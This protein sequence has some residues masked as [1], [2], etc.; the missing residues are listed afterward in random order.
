MQNVTQNNA[1]KLLYKKESYEIRGICFNLYKKFRNAYKEIIYHN[2][3]VHELGQKDFSIEKNKQIPIIY[4]GKKLGV[5]VPDIIV[6]NKILIELKS[7]PFLT[8]DDYNQ[9]WQYLKGSSFKV[10]FLINF[11][12]ANGVEIIRRIYDAARVSAERRRTIE[13]QKDAEKNISRSSAKGSALFSGLKGFT[14]VEIALVVGILV[15]LSSIVLVTLNIRGNTASANNVKRKIDLESIQKALDLRAQETGDSLPSGLSSGLSERCVGTSSDAFNLSQISWSKSP[16]D[17]NISMKV[18]SCAQADCSDG[19]D[20]STLSSYTASPASLNISNSSNFQYQAIFNPS[21]TPWTQTTDNHFN[22]IGSI[23]SSTVVNSNSVKLGISS[24]TGADNSL[25]LSLCTISG[26]CTPAGGCNGSGLSWSGSTCTIATNTK[27]SFNFTT[28]NIPSGTTLTASGSNKITLYATGTVTVG[29]TISL[30]GGNGGTVSTVGVGVAGGGNGGAGGYSE[31]PGSA[32]IGTGGGGYVSGGNTKGGGG[33]FGAAGTNGSVGANGG[34]LYG[35]SVDVWYGGS[36]GGGGDGSSSSGAGGAG[37]GALRIISGST[38]TIATT[39]I[40]RA[41]GGTGRDTSYGDGGG[42]SGGGILLR[43]GGSISNNGSIQARGGVGGGGAGNGAGGRVRMATPSGTGITTGAIVTASCAGTAGA[44][45]VCGGSTNYGTGTSGSFSAT[46]VTSGNYTSSIKGVGTGSNFST[47]S[48]METP[49]GL[50]PANT[51]VKIKVR[52]CDDSACDS[53][54]GYAESAF[55]AITAT[56]CT[57]GSANGCTIDNGGNLTSLS[58]VTNGHG[59]IQYEVTLSNNDDTAKTPSL[60]EITINYYSFAIRPILKDVAINGIA[61]L[62]GDQRVFQYSTYNHFSSG[63]ISSSG[64][65]I[66]TGSADPNNED[67]GTIEYFTGVPPLTYTSPVFSG[68]CHDLAP[69]LAPLYLGS[70][71]KDPKTGTDENTGYLISVD[72][73]TK[74]VCVKAPGAENDEVI[75]NCRK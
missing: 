56:A 45:D 64:S 50:L 5:Y 40:I 23:N 30:N 26:T 75:E 41:N 61:Q 71:P 48:W 15:V 33:G 14:L 37:G 39:G 13:P 53:L 18:R 25:D 65:L 9:F 31:G 55:S 16:L 70:I 3:L 8:K 49:N 35:S 34:S 20:W 42:G 24:G 2:A 54:V 7:K 44:V 51:P 57:G 12:N 59:W 1:E 11:G 63:S 73:A 22:E 46:Y 74:V 29:G 21:I 62:A 10:G 60:D 68:N 66:L 17:A 28:M 32:G 72:P 36:G 52:S 19:A 6:D 67:A 27:S 38:I 47:L 4:N 43:A 58:S 69:D